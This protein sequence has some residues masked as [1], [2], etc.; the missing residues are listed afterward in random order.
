MNAKL[1]PVRAAGSAVAHRPR[2]SSVF[3]LR[4]LIYYTML[5]LLAVGVIKAYLFWLDSYIT[6]HPEVVVA[7]PMGYVE[8]LPLDGILVWDEQLI[9]ATRNGVLTFSSP[10]PR[11]VIRGETLVALD[12]AAIRA[13]STGY[14]VP[15]FD[16]EEGTWVFSRLWPG[17]EE[18]PPF[19]PLRILENGTRVHQ[20]DP[21]GKFVP[22]PQDLRC[23]AYLYR[24]ASLM[25]DIGNG[26]VDIRLNPD[27]KIK[28]TT[29]RAYW[30][31]GQKVKVYLTLP[32]FP[33]SAISTRGFS[34][35]VITGSRQGVTV[36]D[37]AV[38]LRGGRTNV[39]RLLGSITEFSE[40]EGFPI[41]GNNFF[42]TSGLVPGNIVIRYADGLREGFVRLW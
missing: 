38:V 29:V 14:F 33:A 4:K 41:E 25:R 23:I 34:A 30:E 22:Q 12:G 17:M 42:I 15:G 2:V 26:F 5:L 32:F 27:G 13:E 1:R 16:G 19:A 28:R 3:L 24:T 37:S 40:V 39:L 20:G 35:S 6:L 18:L 21:V 11:R 9:T 31:Y 36:P 7:M 10:F 8:E